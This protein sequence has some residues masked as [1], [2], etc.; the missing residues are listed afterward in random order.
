MAAGGVLFVLFV[1]IA[2]VA[3]LYWRRGPA[4][5]A[6]TRLSV[7]TPGTI[8]PQL[9][10]AMSPDGRH[11]AFVSTAGSGKLMLWVRTLD[12]LQAQV[13]AGT[14]NAAHPFWSPDGRSLGFLA[15]G[16]LKTISAF[17]GPI[18]TL[19]DAPIR[20]GASWNRDGTILFPSR[21]ELAAIRAA[22]GP[23]STVLSAPSGSTIV[24]P[25]FLPDGRHFLYFRQSAKPE[26]RGVW[27]GSLESKETSRVLPSE[28][29]AAY[30]SGYVL[31][32]QGEALMAQPFDL[33][34][35]ALTSEPALV[36]DGIWVATGAGQASFSASS[37]GVLAYVSASLKD[38]NAGWFER[39]GRT[40]GP[41]GLPDR[42]D[43]PMQISPD[44]KRVAVGRAVNGVPNI[45]IVDGS[46]P[47]S[48]RVTFGAIRDSTPVW[49][50]DGR[51]IAFQSAQPG[52]ATRILIKN[53]SGAGADDLAFE[54]ANIG[55][56]DWSSDGRFFVF[57]KAGARSLSDLWILPLDGH[58]EPV[59]FLETAFNM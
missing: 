38:L 18:A 53:V 52:G 22:G 4:N 42:Y 40:L 41:L 48:T 58:R 8:S 45:W 43:G 26:E 6:P 11:L 30:A 12:S 23:I 31:F 36:A 44:G 5:T 39:G 21:G 20:A 13:L 49:S 2:T 16:K 15:D 3:A 25:H 46:G 27:I 33:T 59:P 56:A 50:A 19:A 55:L 32:V 51:R 9:S 54:S 17:G 14:E 29:K 1:T 47:A 37:T 24:W 28:F 57:T 35:F 10:A 34:R 7:S